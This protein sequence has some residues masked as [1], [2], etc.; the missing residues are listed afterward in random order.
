MIELGLICVFLVEELGKSGK[1]VII[2]I[3]LF[4]IVNYVCNYDNIIVYIL[5]G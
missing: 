1:Y 4:F 3:I 5:G 2:I